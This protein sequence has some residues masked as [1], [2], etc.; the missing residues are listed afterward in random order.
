M[1]KREI[2][3]IRKKSVILSGLAALEY[4]SIPVLLSVISLLLTGHHLT[5]VNAFM[6]LMYMNL[7][8]LC[9]SLDIGYGVVETHEAYVSLGRIEEFLILED[10]LCISGDQSKEDKGIAPE[11]MSVKLQRDFRVIKDQSEKSQESPVTDQRVNPSEPGTLCVSSLKSTE[12][13]RKDDLILED[14]EFIAAS[15]TLTVIT[16]PVGS[17]KSTL[18]LAIAGEIREISIIRK[19]SVILS[20]LAAL[21]YTSIPVLLSVI[22]LLLTGHHLTPV[23]AFMLLMYMNLLRLCFSLDIGYGVVETHEA[24]VSLG[25]IEEFLILEDLLCISGDQSKEDKGI[26]P[27]EMSVKL[28][29]DFRVIKDQ[30]EKSH[31]SPVTDQR[32]NPSEP[33]TLCVSSLKSTEMKRKDDLIL[34]DVE[35]IAASGTLTVITGPVGSGKSTLLLAIAGEMSDISGTISR[36]GTFVYAPQVA[37]V[38]SG[39]LRENI[40]FGESYNESRYTRVIEACALTKD[41]QQFP[42]GDETVVGERGAVLSGG[43]RARVNLARAVYVDADLYLLD[44]PLSAVDFKVGRHIFEKCIKDVLGKRT[45][46]LTSHQESHM[47]DADQVIMLYKGRVLGKGTFVELQ[48]KGIL[49]TTIYPLCKNTLIEKLSDNTARDNEEKLSGVMP[50]ATDS[51]GLEIS[52]EDR[53]IGTVSSKLYWD[54]FRSGIHP[55]LIIG[56][57]ILC[58]IP[59]ASMVAPDV[60]LSLLTRKRPSE[61]KD[62]TNLAIYG[63]LVAASFLLG[64]VR[65]YILF[66]VCLRCSERLHDKMVVALLQAPVLFFDSNPVGRILNRFSKDVGCMDELLPLQFLSTVQLVLLLFS[67][68]IVPSVTNPWLVFVTIPVTATSLYFARFYLKSSRELKRLESMCR[69]PV[70]SHISETLEGLDT[71]RSRGR[72]ND[73]IEEFYSLRR[74][75]SCLCHSNSGSDTI[76]CQK[77]V[78]CREFYDVS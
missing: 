16:G 6:L 22:S 30:S 49:N 44:D 60:W 45:R 28:Q 38:F 57:V 71:I 68:V 42:N 11:E 8:R 53:A 17:G 72:Q 74:T 2:S 65:C 31:E 63:C 18:L 55:L 20:G 62:K 47:I 3:I 13:K 27:E 26:A 33:G 54:Y 1:D 10:L 46:L 34:E 73:F 78:R 59:Q 5:P 19:K 51:N 41:F 9:F 12:M 23:N 75:C 61:Q 77:I 35:F 40:L 48:D 32:V 24:Y 50:L 4:T 39:T 15:G 67:S 69:S 66:L 43:Q 56:V 52:V 29:R 7:L 76:R 21:E 70:F 14:V 37:W 64:I 58:L 25:R 36:H